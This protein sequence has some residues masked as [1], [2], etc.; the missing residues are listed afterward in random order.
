MRIV[1]VVE[2][3]FDIAGLEEIASVLRENELDADEELILS[4]E[5][6]TSGKNV[7]RV[8][9]TLVTLNYLKSLTDR[10]VDVHGQHEHQSLISQA[11]H[12]H[13]L[14]AFGGEA[15]SRK[16]ASVASVYTEYNKLRKARLSGFTSEDERARQIDILTYQTR[17]IEG[18]KLYEGEEA[19][20]MEER[21]KLA[22]AE[23]ILSALHNCSELIAGDEGMA[24]STSTALGELRSIRMLASE[25]EELYGKLESAHYALEDIGYN[26]REMK[27]SFEYDPAR[28]NEVEQRLE[29]YSVLKRKYGADYPEIMAYLLIAQTK[30]AELTDSEE[31]REELDKKIRVCAEQY[32]FEAKRLTDLRKKAAEDLEKSLVD[33][34]RDLGMERTVFRVV[35]SELSSFAANGMDKVDFMLSANPGEP[36]KPLEKVASGGELSRIMLAFKA[37]ASSAY[38]IPTLIFDEIDVGISGR[39]AAIVGEK[40]VEIADSHQVICITHLPQIAAQADAHYLV[41]KTSDDVSTKTGL[42]LLDETAHCRSIAAMMSGSANTATGLDHARELVAECNLKK[43]KR[44]GN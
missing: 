43:Q 7:C 44:R 21:S 25:Y 1:A 8:N 19:G 42:R 12:L 5:L 36:L 24:A 17:E 6:S 13:F 14:D 2:A 15:L 9:G 29:T 37:V 16:K 4:R 33:Q 22:N 20:L 10:L 34:L 23:R 11:N 39:I 32:T 28:F 26:L 40:M 30:L 35:F 27:D 31:A 18:A 3:V 38:G 41:E